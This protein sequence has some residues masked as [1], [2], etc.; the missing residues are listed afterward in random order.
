MKD[1]KFL[2]FAILLSYLSVGVRRSQDHTDGDFTVGKMAN[3]SFKGWQTL[4]GKVFKLT[5]IYLF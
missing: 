5:F 3:S 2:L 1:N 4:F